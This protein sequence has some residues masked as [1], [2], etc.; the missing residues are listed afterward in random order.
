LQVTDNGEGEDGDIHDHYYRDE[1]SDSDDDDEY[2][3]AQ[4]KMQQQR[5]LTLE[6]SLAAM[7]DLHRQIA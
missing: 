4:Q 6:G 2:D 5:L 1:Q 7:H 3:L